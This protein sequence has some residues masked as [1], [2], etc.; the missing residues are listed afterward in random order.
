MGKGEQIARYRNT[1]VNVDDFVIAELSDLFMGLWD[2][3][4]PNLVRYNPALSICLT[5]CR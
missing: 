4:Q 3:A 1:L 5:D 2:N